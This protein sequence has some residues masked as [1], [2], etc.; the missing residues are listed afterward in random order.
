MIKGFQDI[1]EGKASLS[2]GF[3]TV[4]EQGLIAAGGALGAS[5]V[6]ARLGPKKVG[7]RK[8]CKRSVT[9]QF[10]VFDYNLS[11]LPDFGNR[12]LPASFREMETVQWTHVD[13]GINA[14]FSTFLIIKMFLVGHPRSKIYFEEVCHQLMPTVALKV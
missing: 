6:K 9:D 7:Y 12:S 13:Q 4:A 8:L 11:D 5:G 3:D 1:H 10:D 2:S 14:V